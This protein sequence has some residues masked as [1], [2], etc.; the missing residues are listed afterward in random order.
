[1]DYALTTFTDP[2]RPDS[3][4]AAAASVD[5]VELGALAEKR[6][7]HCQGPKPPRTHHCRV[8]RRCV[9]KMDHHCP[10]VANCVGLRNYRHF[11][12]L[13]VELVLGCFVLAVSL[14]PQLH[15]VVSRSVVDMTFPRQLHIVAAAAVAVFVCFVLG[16]FF[17]FHL[18]L[19]IMNQTTLEFMARRSSQRQGKGTNHLVSYNRGLLENF[20]EVCGAPPRWCRRPLEELLRRLVLLTFS[21]SAKRSA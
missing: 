5:L 19:L 11:C 10:F 14:A 8:C 13:L 1:M 15:L 9:L 16:P 21:P 2:G 12:R 17:F 6:C 7:R 20:S 4:D 3:S 18:Q